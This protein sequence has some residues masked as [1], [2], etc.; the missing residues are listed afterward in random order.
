MMGGTGAEMD[1]RKGGRKERTICVS[2]EG[3]KCGEEGEE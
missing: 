1:K 3:G 2:V